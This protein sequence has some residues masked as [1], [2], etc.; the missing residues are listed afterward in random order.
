MLIELDR[1]EYNS[2]P[3]YSSHSVRMPDSDEDAMS[4][5][6]RDKGIPFS[7]IIHENLDKDRLYSSLSEKEQTVLRPC[8]KEDYTQTE[9]AKELR[10][11]QGYISR[12]LKLAREK[13][14]YFKN[15]NASRATADECGALKIVELCFCRQK[16]KFTRKYNTR[17]FFVLY[18]KERHSVRGDCNCTITG[19]SA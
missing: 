2:N 6:L 9:A 18:G 11:I 16:T 5:A 1:L 12:L 10:V 4:P 15:K 19:N 8:E 14:F 17:W 3:A 7:H 13:R